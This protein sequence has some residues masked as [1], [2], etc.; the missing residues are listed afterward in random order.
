MSKHNNEYLETFER[1]KE[2]RDQLSALRGD[3]ASPDYTKTL[4]SLSANLR[5]ISQRNRQ[6]AAMIVA[7]SR[8]RH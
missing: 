2:I 7:H 5:N 4:L 3:V 6:I 1:Q 8:S